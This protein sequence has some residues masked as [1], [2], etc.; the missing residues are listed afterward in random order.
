LFAG[1]TILNFDNAPVEQPPGSDLSTGGDEQKAFFMSG[2]LRWRPTSRLSIQIRPFSSI[3][4]S[5]VF[6]TSTFRQTGF[7]LSARQTF[8]KRVFAQGRFSYINDNFE[9]GRTD[10]RL[11]W[12]MGLGYR[13]VKWLGFR[14]DY[15]FSKR[16]STESEFE[17]YSN[18]IMFTV[19]GLLGASID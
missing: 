12:R 13:T 10:N 14:L 5:A 15:I 18:T 1:I 19:Q 4:Q 2:S 9:A 7:R 17:F 8:N 6:E 3:R 16:F 11:R